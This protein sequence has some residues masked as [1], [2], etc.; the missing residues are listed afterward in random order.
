MSLLLLAVILAYLAG[1][2]PTAVWTSRILLKDDIRN[3]GSGN[4]GATNV[5]RVMGWKPAL[6]VV[7]VDMGKGVLATM[8]I[9]RLGMRSLSLD[10]VWVQILTGIAAIL[11]HV[12]TV[13]AGFRGGKGVGTAFGVLLGLAPV[14]FL[15][16][17]VVWL[18]LVFSTRVVSVAS[19]SAGI[20]F[21]IALFIQRYGFHSDIH[22]A[23][24]YLSVFLAV[25]I[26]LTHRSNIQRLIRSEENKFGTKK[27]VKGEER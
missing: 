26:L 13:F 18:V 21:P 20:V 14:A 9:A 16:S 4:A 5:F 17:G 6:F 27:E 10:P 23:L 8:V 15:A 1:S 12:W 25:L 22:Y 2:I 11:G 7:L 19:I 24:L 3:H